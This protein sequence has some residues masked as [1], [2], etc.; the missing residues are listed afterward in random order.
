MIREHIY[1]LLNKKLAQKK[2][3]CIKL[4]WQKVELE[5]KLRQLEQMNSS[6]I[7]F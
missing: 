3:E 1:K 5:N 6:K 4:E 2:H 7:N